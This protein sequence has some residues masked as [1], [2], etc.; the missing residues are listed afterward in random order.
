MNEL[1]GAVQVD[2]LTVLSV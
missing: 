2:S 1:L